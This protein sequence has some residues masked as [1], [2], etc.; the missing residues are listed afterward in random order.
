MTETWEATCE[1]PDEV[2]LIRAWV[3]RHPGV[4]MERMGGKWI[5]VYLESGDEED[6]FG[7]FC[8]D[9]AIECRLV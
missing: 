3:Q 7:E 4:T 1:T 9:Y 8:D 6:E 5:N 2:N